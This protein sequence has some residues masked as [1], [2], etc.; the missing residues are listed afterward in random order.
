[1][2]SSF[3]AWWKS[4]LLLVVAVMLAAS[5][6]GC[7]PADR[8]DANRA[9]AD[10][11]AQCKLGPRNP[12]SKAHQQCLELI[13]SRLKAAGL[14][15]K[16]EKFTYSLDGHEYEGTNIIARLGPQQGP[17]K[18]MLGAHWDTRPWADRD[19]DPANRNK[20][21]LGAND[22]ASGVAV[23]LELARCLQAQHVK[24]PLDLVFFDAE[25]VGRTT[26]EFCQGSFFY[27]FDKNIQLPEKAI[28]IDMIGD[29]DLH[30]KREQYS[31]ERAPELY[32]ALWKIASKLGAQAFEPGSWGQI[33]DDHR[34][35][36]LA[37]VEA[38]DLIDFDYPAWHTLQDTP[39]KCSAASLDQ[40]G[41]VLTAYI[42]SLR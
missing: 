28:I 22:G 5:V 7:Q 36:Q 6:A 41:E 23:L 30:I 38:V 12:G 17:A 2:K 24:V 34:P 32:A 10:L 1:M 15:V 18:L 19:A 33:Y 39:D 26:F 25:D 8:F 29:K 16:E 14:P 11:M 37:G 4:W 31:E 20:P 21:I 3:S 27:A 42:L 40:V 9:W 35:L 13:E